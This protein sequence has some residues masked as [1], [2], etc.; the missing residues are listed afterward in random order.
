MLIVILFLSRIGYMISLLY[1]F[2]RS[3]RFVYTVCCL[4]VPY[5]CEW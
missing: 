3:V 5:A 2:L 4:G 1:D